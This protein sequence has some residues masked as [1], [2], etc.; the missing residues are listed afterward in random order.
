MEGKVLTGFRDVNGKDIKA[1]D[2][3][4]NPFWG[5]YWRVYYDSDE[6][7]WIA[8][9]LAND[10]NHGGNYETDL[11]DVNDTFEIVENGIVE[12]QGYVEDK[13]S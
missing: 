1:G 10:Y 3:L 6:K 9:L 13:F 2:L 5:D 11:D 7:L 8:S 12:H 4:F